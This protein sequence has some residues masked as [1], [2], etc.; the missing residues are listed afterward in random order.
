MCNKRPI[1]DEY[2]FI[3]ECDRYTDI[4]CQ[5]IKTYYYRNPFTF[6]LI[7]LCLKVLHDV[8]KSLDLSEIKIFYTCVINKVFL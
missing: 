8:Y 1:E 7:Q 2:H 3:L 5:Y 6:K 4:R